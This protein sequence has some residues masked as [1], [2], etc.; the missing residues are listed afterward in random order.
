MKTTTILILGGMAALAL[1]VVRKAKAAPVL[2]N[3][4]V[5]GT[6]T[7]AADGTVAYTGNADV[8]HPGGQLTL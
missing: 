1:F 4:G 6:Y 7:V 5:P 2:D 8:Y 3:L